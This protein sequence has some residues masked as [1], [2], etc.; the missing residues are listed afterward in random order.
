MVAAWATVGPA[1]SSARELHPLLEQLVGRQDAVDDAPVEHLLGVVEAA[2]HHELPRPGGAGALGHALDAA[3]ERGQSDDPLDEAELGALGRPDHV[4]A[5]R[6]LEAGGQAE[7][8]DEREGRDLERLERLQLADAVGGEARSL[9]APGDVGEDAADVDAA[10]EHPALGAEDH[11]AGA[12]GDDLVAGGAHRLERLLGE[13]VERRVVEDDDGDVALVLDADRRP[14]GFL[15]HWPSLDG[16]C[17]CGDLVH[18]GPAGDPRQLQRIVLVAGDDVDVEVEDG[19]PG[20]GPGRVEEVEAVGLQRGLHSLGD[21]LGGDGAVAEVVGVDLQQV[22]GVPARDHQ[23][24]PARRRIDVHQRHRVLVGVD[25]LGGQIAGDDRAEDAVGARYRL[26]AAD[27]MRA[28]AI[29]RRPRPAGARSP[30]PAWSP[31][32]RTGH[33]RARSRPRRAAGPGSIPTSAAISS[34]RSSGAGGPSISQGD[35]GGEHL[36]GEVEVAGD[37]LLGDSAALGGEAVGDGQQR[38]VDRLRRRS[39]S[40]T[41]RPAGAAAA[42]P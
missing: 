17:D 36:A 35:R 22:G 31:R 14:A 19:L 39:G 11:R 33:P 23:R 37:R 20:G 24:V 25:D 15:G 32:P 34:P 27:A 9:L 30:R 21:P 16:C 2:G 38:R 26:A 18:V 40:G 8:V 7:A 5:Q 1:A 13:Q 10:R 41:P 3:A 12:R 29:G 6:G 42:A 4:A 28:Q